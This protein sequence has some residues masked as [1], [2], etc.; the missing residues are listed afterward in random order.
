MRFDR[1]TL[2][3]GVALFISLSLNLF[4]AGMMVGGSINARGAI[5]QQ[6]QQLRNSLSAADKQVLK[7]AMEANRAQI[8]KLHDDLQNIKSEIRKLIKRDSLDKKALVKVLDAQKLK[9]LAL[10]QLVHDTRKEATDKMSPE[11]RD[12][13]SQMSRLGFNLHAQCR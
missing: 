6:D 9:E 7:E 2:I 3:L 12:I 11:G 4:T 1:I 13:L 8:T 5:E 10:V